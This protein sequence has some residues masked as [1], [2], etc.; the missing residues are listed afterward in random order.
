MNRRS[1]FRTGMALAA[2]WVLQPLLFRRGSIA[3]A[4]KPA[5]ERPVLKMTDPEAKK[6]GYNYDAMLVDTKKWKKKAGP[7]GDRQQCIN[8]SRYTAIDTNHGNC[9]VFPKNTVNWNGWCNS[10]EKKT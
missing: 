4:A 2:S 3:W 9:D 6:N 1:F 5:P 7:D 10:W 8:C